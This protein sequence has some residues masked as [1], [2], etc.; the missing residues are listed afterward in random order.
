MS[1]VEEIRMVL[2]Q[3]MTARHDRIILCKMD[4]FEVLRPNQ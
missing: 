1:H 4:R 3:W 2:R